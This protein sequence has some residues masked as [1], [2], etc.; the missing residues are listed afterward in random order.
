MKRKRIISYLF[1]CTLLMSV[2]IGCGRSLSSENEVVPQFVFRYAE[3]QAA[4]YPTTLGANKFAELVEERTG[5]RIKIVVFHSAQLGSEV[6]CIEQLRIGGID[7]AR[8]S[9]TQLA[10]VEP[11]FNV[12]HLPYLYRDEEH[13][14]QVLDSEI[15]NH[16]LGALEKQNILGLSWYTAGS[17][18]FYTTVPIESLGDFKGL[19]I[20]VQEST[21]AAEMV[22]LIGATASPI[23]FSDVYSALQTGRIDGA[24]NNW[25]SY[26]STSHY[27]VA[28][29]YYWTEHTRVPEMQ[30]ISQEALQK[31]SDEDM[32]IIRECAKESALFQRQE[33]GK[34]TE[35]SK[36]ICYENGVEVILPKAEDIALMQELCRPLYE[37]YAADYMDIVEQIFAMGL[38]EAPGVMGEAKN[39]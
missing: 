12:L 3:N 18:S 25:P 1:I 7:F 27:E 9:L 14:W 8:L 22:R 21:M 4:D 16:F 34:R 15:G 38:E 19:N 2:Q 33:W 11:S 36:K 24:E 32:E 6:E 5:G 26:E 17:R 30:V 39:Q 13:M 35:R 10:E 28:Q 20:R 29:Y 37:K 23:V 31:L